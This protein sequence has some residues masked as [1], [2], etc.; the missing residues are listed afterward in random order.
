M[1]NQRKNY[2]G[3]SQIY[4]ESA[5]AYSDLFKENVAPVAEEEKTEPET[6]NGVIANANRVRLRRTPSTAEDNIIKVLTRDTKV[7]ILDELPNFYKVKTE[8]GILG[9]VVA[10]FCE[11]V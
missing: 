6:R 2:F 1:K 7:E 10:Y 11:E 5:S 4:D 8:D 9:Y 3:E